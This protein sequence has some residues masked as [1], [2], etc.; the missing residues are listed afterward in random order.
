MGKMELD[1]I[2]YDYFS[3]TSSYIKTI[4]DLL[5]ESKV[6]MEKKMNYRKNIWKDF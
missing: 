1:N 6:S 5:P 2:Y 3:N 4:L